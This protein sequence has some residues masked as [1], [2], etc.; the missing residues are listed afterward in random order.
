MEYE[1]KMEKE[2]ECKFNTKKGESET[3]KLGKKKDVEEKPLKRCKDWC[4]EMEGVACGYDAKA[5]MCTVY[6]SGFK[7]MEEASGKNSGSNYCGKIIGTEHESED[8]EEEEVPEIGIGEEASVDEEEEEEETPTGDAEEP[9]VECTLKAHLG[10][11]FDDPDDAAYYGYHAENLEVTMVG[12]DYWV[13]SWYYSD[14][15]PEWCTY[16]NSDPNGD[17]AYV[18]NL[19]DYYYDDIDDLETITEETIE[20]TGV[21]GNSY[22]FK[23]EA[24]IFPRDYYTNYD[25]WADHMNVATLTIEGENGELNEDGWSYEASK[26]VSTHIKQNGKW[27]PNP[28]YEGEFTV[29]VT[30]SEE[31]ECEAS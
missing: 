1:L 30:C 15:L 26:D 24:Y 19:E 8:E 21:A 14:D 13:C 10:Y 29:T 16:E 3:K 28:D 18:A 23:V 7:G 31:C 11:P 25:T 12:D 9:A 27:V 17:S 4:I 22:E 5:R 6:K 20:I 2:Q